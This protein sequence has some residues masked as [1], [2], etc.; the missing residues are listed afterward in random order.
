MQVALLI[1]STLTG[2][3]AAI[4]RSFSEHTGFWMVAAFF[5]GKHMPEKI[6]VTP[7]QFWAWSRD[8]IQ[9]YIATK[10][11]APQHPTQPAPTTPGEKLNQ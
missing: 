5:L 8:A 6:P 4:G 9:S 11:P 1:L 7:Q 2:A 10:E 3:F